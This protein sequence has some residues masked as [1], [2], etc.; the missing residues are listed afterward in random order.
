MDPLACRQAREVVPPDRSRQETAVGPRRRRG[1]ELSAPSVKCWKNRKVDMSIRRTLATLWQS[2]FRRSQLDRELDDELR[3]YLDDLIQKKIRAGQDPAT[4]RRAA[5]IEMGG[6]TQVKVEVRRARPGAGI[7]ALWQDVRFSWRALLR[8]PAFAT[9]TIITFALGIG[10][11][12]AIFS[13]VNSILIQP[14]PYRDPSQLVSVWIDMTAAG[15]PKA[16]LSGPELGDL[17]QRGTLF[18]S[19]GGIWP[20]STTITGDANPN[21]SRSDA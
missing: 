17:R 10:S 13:I 9:V 5:M 12:T 19:F 1:R 18:S 4:A 16:P 2:L 14:L 20:N 7:D 8:K 6:M 11:N 3:G 15:F 21:S